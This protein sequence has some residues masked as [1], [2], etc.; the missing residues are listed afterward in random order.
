MIEIYKI[1][2]NIYDADFS[3]LFTFKAQTALV[4]PVEA[5]HLKSSYTTPD[6]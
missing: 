6:Y 2:H 4:A 3:N 1:V 5:I